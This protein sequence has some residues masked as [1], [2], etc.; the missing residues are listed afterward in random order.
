MWCLQEGRPAACG[1]HEAR[2]DDEEEGENNNEE[3]KEAEKEG[4]E[5]GGTAA[6]GGG[7]DQHRTNTNTK[8]Q[9]QGSRQEEREEEGSLM[10]EGDRQ[11]QR[12]QQQKRGGAQTGDGMES[13]PV[14]IADVQVQLPP[15]EDSRGAAEE[16]EPGVGDAE[17]SS[18]CPLP[19]INP[20]LTVRGNTL[21]VYGGLLEVG[22]FWSS[23]MWS[24]FFC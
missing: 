2:D 3:E 13:S 4:E 15:T 6:D 17:E 9:S 21:Y 10:L 20:C 23:V 22:I 11:Q 7:V 18:P 12:Q 19:R 8:R 5:E 1:T 14:N 16:A 24:N